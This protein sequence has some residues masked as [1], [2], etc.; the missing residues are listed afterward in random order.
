MPELAD[1]VQRFVPVGDSP[2]TAIEGLSLFRQTAPTNHVPS[3]C[4]PSL[5]IIAQGAKQ[6]L[7]A[8]H[9]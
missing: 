3:V 8:L 9:R 1:L 6:V 5:C 4:E 2:A 7:I